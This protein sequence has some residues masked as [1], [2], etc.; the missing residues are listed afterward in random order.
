MFQKH[1]LINGLLRIILEI[2]IRGTV[3][4]NIVILQAGLQRIIDDLFHQNI[5]F[6]WAEI[7]DLELLWTHSSMFIQFQTVI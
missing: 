1:V 4:G 3:D 7:E 6:A 5:A 2:T